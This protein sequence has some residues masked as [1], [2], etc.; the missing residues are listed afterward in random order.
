MILFRA[1]GCGRIHKKLLGHYGQ[2]T[3]EQHE[4]CLGLF[5]LFERLSDADRVWNFVKSGLG[6]DLGSRWR[7]QTGRKSVLDMLARSLTAYV[8]RRGRQVQVAV[9]AHPVTARL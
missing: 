7:A 5:M 1:F 3:D 4:K 8:T 6:S 9:A 2:I